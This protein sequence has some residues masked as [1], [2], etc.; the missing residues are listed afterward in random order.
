MS[1]KIEVSKSPEYSLFSRF[2]DNFSALPYNVVLSM[3]EKSQMM[4]II[5]NVICN[6][7]ELTFSS[8]EIIKS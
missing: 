1:G 7:N 5:R 6:M 4:E 2:K 3:T 8:G